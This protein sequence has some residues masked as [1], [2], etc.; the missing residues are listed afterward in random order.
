MRYFIPDWDDL[1]D[2][3]YDFINDR[4]TPGKRKY[5]DEVYAHQLYAQPNYDGLLFSRSG[6]EDGAFKT[7]LTR[8]LG[9]Y[10]FARF[11]G[12]ILGD[13]G[14]FSYI[15]N[16]VPP[17]QTPE[18]LEYYQ[19]MDFD[20]GVSIDH[21][22]V[23][24]FYPAKEFRYR[25]TRENA[26]EF[27]QL[28]QAGGYTFTPIGIA[29]GWSPETYKEVVVE[30]LNWGY[31]YIGLGGL[32]RANTHEIYDVVKAIAPVLREDTDLHLFGVARDRECE[33]MEMFRRLGVTSFDS[34]SYLR[35]A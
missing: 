24:A 11:Q 8:E 23:P 34:A 5:Y 10:T 35:R 29:Q 33:E 13:C 7:S 27:I 4:G 20:Y 18:I 17:Y 21:L 15:S 14:T 30:L 31:Q 12:P 19:K 16:E 32:T 26:R 2:P 6:V 22:I 9:I 28:H 3:G 25:L 1:V